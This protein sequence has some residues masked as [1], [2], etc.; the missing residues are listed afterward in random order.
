M[1]QLSAL[2]HFSLVYCF[3]D[4]KST[5]SSLTAI[6]WR[7]TALLVLCSTFVFLSF[8]MWL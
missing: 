1:L 4:G 5:A 8:T 2:P 6:V 3:S 7:A